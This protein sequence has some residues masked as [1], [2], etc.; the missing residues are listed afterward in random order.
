MELLLNFSMYVMALLYILAGL[1]H[2][3]KPK[4]YLPMM[5]SYIPKHAL[6]I[7]LSGV[8]EVFLGLGILWPPTRSI[9]AFGIILL[10]IVFLT[11]H[12]DMIQNRKRFPTIPVWILWA[13]LPLQ[14]VLMIWA[15]IFI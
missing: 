10:L 1:I 13:R 15:G 7:F 9:A 3:L 6:M 5:P 12:V 4:I 8:A 11:V 14:F 2:F